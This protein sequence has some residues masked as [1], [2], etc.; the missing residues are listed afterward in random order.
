M[1]LEKVFRRLPP[2]PNYRDPDGLAEPHQ[3]EAFF[4]RPR[5]NPLGGA[6]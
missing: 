4:T 3:T 5:L 2:S 1:Q 6:T